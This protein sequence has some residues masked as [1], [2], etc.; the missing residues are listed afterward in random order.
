MWKNANFQI[1]SA[2][3]MWDTFWGVR[4]GK[5][6]LL[7]GQDRKSAFV[8][9][10]KFVRSR[11]SVLII[12]VWWTRGVHPKIKGL[13]WAFD[14]TFSSGQNDHLKRRTQS[15]KMTLCPLVIKCS[16]WALDFIGR[17]SLDDRWQ[18]QWGK[19]TI[20]FFG[21]LSHIRSSGE[22]RHLKSS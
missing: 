11:S 9:G 14:L 7:L 16:F 13:K 18:K 3:S 19:M 15:V 8:D 12:K 5:M 6:L 2:F 17:F 22:F 4:N 10:Y 1:Q 21:Q 20:W